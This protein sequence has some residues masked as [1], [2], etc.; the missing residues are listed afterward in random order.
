MLIEQNIFGDVKPSCRIKT[1]VPFMRRRIPQKF[2]LLGSEFKFV[3]IVGSGKRE[4]RATKTLEELV[5]REL[6]MQHKIG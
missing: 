1:L 6:K 3:I 4:T 2:A 5:I